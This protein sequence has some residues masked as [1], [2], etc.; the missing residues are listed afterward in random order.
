MISSYNEDKKC[1]VC[2]TWFNGFGDTCTI[3][4]YKKIVNEIILDLSDRRGLGNEWDQIDEDIQ[5]EIKE[6]WVGIIKYNL[7]K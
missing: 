3:C 7:I 2:N 4:K 6:T 5:E 1:L